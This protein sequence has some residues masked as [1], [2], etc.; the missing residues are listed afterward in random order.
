MPRKQREIAAGLKSKGFDEDSTGHHVY[1]FL[2]DD[3][4]KK[5]SVRTKMS[6]QSGGV[7]IGDSLLR[8]MAR[9]VKLTKQDFLSLIDC[10][11]TREEYLKKVGTD[12]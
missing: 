3:E 8:Q 6:H 2:I 12:I 5:T 11:L 1:F 10:P 4:G 7:E 9:Q